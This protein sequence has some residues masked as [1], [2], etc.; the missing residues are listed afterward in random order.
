MTIALGPWWQQEILGIDPKMAEVA[1]SGADC[2]GHVDSTQ[3]WM[4]CIEQLLK[5]EWF[6]WLPELLFIPVLDIYLSVA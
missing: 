2:L 6:A 1:D 4:M 3:C 5:V